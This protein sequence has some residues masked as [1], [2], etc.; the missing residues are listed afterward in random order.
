M[1]KFSQLQ[2]R[3]CALDI[4]SKAERMADHDAQQAVSE[5][6]YVARPNLFAPKAGAK[7]AV[8]GFDAVAPVRQ[9]PAFVGVRI[10][11]FVLEGSQQLESGFVLPQLFLKPG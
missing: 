6:P 11:L 1:S 7:L 4:E 5:M 9:E 3:V 10:T 8:D 2:W